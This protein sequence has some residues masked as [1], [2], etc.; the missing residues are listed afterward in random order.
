VVIL[1]SCSKIYTHLYWTIKD[2]VADGPEPEAAS[3]VHVE[4]FHGR[5]RARVVCVQEK[6]LQ[7]AL[8]LKM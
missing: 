4:H 3:L 8:S 7:H 1:L 6:L 5:V 2:A